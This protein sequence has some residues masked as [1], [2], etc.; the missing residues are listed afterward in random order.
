MNA[1]HITYT[2]YIRYISLV[3][4]EGSLLPILMHIFGAAKYAFDSLIAFGTAQKRSSVET[5]TQTL[6]RVTIQTNGCF[7]TFIYTAYT[8]K[9]AESR[10]LVFI[11]QPREEV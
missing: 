7:P 1:S 5:K 2:I 6:K 3:V 8:H 9:S 10:T 4:C 11:L